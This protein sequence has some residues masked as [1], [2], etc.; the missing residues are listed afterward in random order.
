LFF[1]HGLQFIIIRA[2]IF[3]RTSAKKCTIFKA[4]D[5][6][7]AMKNPSNNLEGAAAAWVAGGK[8]AGKF[9]GV[10]PRSTDGGYWEYPGG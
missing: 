5:P 8:D 7:W 10:L 2:R 1:W 4:A 3:S 6:A 9:P